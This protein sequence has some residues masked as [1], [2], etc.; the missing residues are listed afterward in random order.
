MCSKVSW[1]TRRAARRAGRRMPAD[2]HLAAYWCRKHQAWHIGHL[3]PAVIHG[4]RSRAE[5]YR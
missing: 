2:G 4:L 3:A 5:V 1:S